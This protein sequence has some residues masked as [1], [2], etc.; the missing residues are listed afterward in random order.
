MMNRPNGRGPR[1]YVYRVRGLQQ[2]D[3]LWVQS[4]P[5]HTVR[6]EHQQVAA[7][8]Y[9]AELPEQLQ[10]ACKRLVVE[11][12]SGGYPIEDWIMDRHGSPIIDP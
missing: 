9:E 1:N 5:T 12:L 11:R 7:L 4:A 3:G 6:A 2:V 10:R 8:T